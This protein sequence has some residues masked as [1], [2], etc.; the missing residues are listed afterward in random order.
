VIDD[1]CVRSEQMGVIGYR[2][3]LCH[4]PLRR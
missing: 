3:V 4:A 1:D 2:R